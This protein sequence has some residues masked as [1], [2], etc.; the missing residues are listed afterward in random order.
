MI[1]KLK[2]NHNEDRAQLVSILAFAGYKVSVEHQKAE[3]PTLGM[4]D[5]FVI[6]EDKEALP[7]RTLGKIAAFKHA[8]KIGARENGNE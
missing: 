1:A 2:V 6:V 8:L 4:G 3:R 7:T 5:Y